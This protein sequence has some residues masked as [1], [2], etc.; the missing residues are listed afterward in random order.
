[1]QI[2]AVSLF[3]YFFGRVMRRYKEAIRR[4]QGLPIASKIFAVQARIL[5]RVQERA[6]SQ[7]AAKDHTM[8]HSGNHD[9]SGRRKGGI[10]E[11]TDIPE[12]LPQ[13]LLDY[14][15]GLAAVSCRNERSAGIRRL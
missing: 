7:K 4:L 3:L 6:I 15:R 12:I 1:M 13:I 10:L 5:Y 11:R 9:G 2:R 8:R 14:R